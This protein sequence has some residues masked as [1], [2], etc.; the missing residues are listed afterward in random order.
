MIVVKPLRELIGGSSPASARR[1]R[2]IR[3]R[4]VSC[5]ISSTRSHFCPCQISTSAARTSR[6]AYERKKRRSSSHIF[7][8]EK[9][10]PAAGDIS[11]TAGTDVLLSANQKRI[12]FRL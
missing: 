5:T 4:T 2:S 8:S 3:R 11:E 12:Y 7:S 10:P 1:A 6:Q 9:I